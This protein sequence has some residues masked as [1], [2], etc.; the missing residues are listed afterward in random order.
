MSIEHW[1]ASGA[2]DRIDQLYNNLVGSPIPVPKNQMPV[3]QALL[4]LGDVFLAA[5]NRE[6]LDF[7]TVRSKL[8]SPYIGNAI[9]LDNI[10]RAKGWKKILEGNS[11]HITWRE[12]A[13]FWSSLANALV[14]ANTAISI[15]SPVN[16]S[17]IRS[18]EIG[19][20]IQFFSEGLPSAAEMIRRGSV[21]SRIGFHGSMLHAEHG[22]S[23]AKFNRGTYRETVAKIASVASSVTALG[24]I[25]ASWVGLTQV[26]TYLSTA[27]GVLGSIKFLA[28]WNDAKPGNELLH[29]KQ[30]MDSA[31]NVFLDELTRKL[32]DP[33]IDKW[34][35]LEQ[36]IEINAIKNTI[37]S[38]CI[39]DLGM[40]ASV[41][42]FSQLKHQLDTL[43]LLSKTT[44]DKADRLSENIGK[45]VLEKQ[46]L[47]G[48]MNAELLEQ[49][50][51]LIKLSLT[52]EKRL[53]GLDKKYGD[54]KNEKQWVK[55]ELEML[56]NSIRRDMSTIQQLLETGLDSL[57]ISNWLRKANVL[58]D[59]SRVNTLNSRLKS[60]STPPSAVDQLHL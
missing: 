46:S 15:Y 49:D 34:M 56:K 47:I 22:D 28:S 12:K 1:N 10:V 57:D 30:E 9:A 32:K 52:I 25:A 24:G 11:P 17:V 14:L 51:Y 44:S 27:S 40:T 4:F 19:K 42:I 38:I 37:N 6:T 16:P 55:S 31:L 26:S 41:M 59:P 43:K 8:L 33:K 45:A 58:T 20:K 54:Y 36:I 48:R 60:A 50:A 29:L 18:V 13:A 5:T 2:Q 3:M 23:T 21:I 35:V 53:E 39:N 7:F